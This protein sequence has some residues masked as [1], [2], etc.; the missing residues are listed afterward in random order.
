[1]KIVTVTYDQAKGTLTIS[2]EDIEIVY[3]QGDWVEWK[4]HNIP[5]GSFGYLRFD[6]AP[7]LGPFHS[8]RTLAQKS[9]VGK[10]NTGATSN[11]THPYEAMLLS[12]KPPGVLAV[13]SK[14]FV[15]QEAA[16]PNTTP[17]IKVTYE[18]KDKAL[19]VDP[20]EIGL[21]LG[22][23]ATWHFRGFP[24]GCFA[25]L[26]FDSGEASPHPFADF[27]ITAPLPG[28]PTGTFRAHGIGFRTKI[29]EESPQKYVVQVLDLPASLS[30]HIQVR[31]SL[32][33]I[34]STD[35]PLIDNLG[36]PIPD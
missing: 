2:P 31:D 14:A 16:D 6:N 4:F 1:M 5:P 24:E 33:V 26:Q 9:V 35:D 8:L 19:V 27:Y 18:G 3:K 20:M 22:D 32:G 21:N 25:T 36:P 23:T 17:D 28:E 29:V 15:I 10:G 11:V 30:Y 13:S 7:A 34:V 12:R